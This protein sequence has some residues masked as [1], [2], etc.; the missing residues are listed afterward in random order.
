MKLIHNSTPPVDM[1]T[2]QIAL[3][4][5]A[6]KKCEAYKAKGDHFLAKGKAKRADQ[7]FRI[8]ERALL[9]FQTMACLLS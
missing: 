4:E 3:A 8:A 7:A 2:V 9:R 6:L 5:R 1:E